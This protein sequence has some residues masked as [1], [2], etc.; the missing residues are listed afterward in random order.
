MKKNKNKKLITTARIILIITTR[1]NMNK[2]KN[3]KNE[4]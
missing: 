3:N 4:T 2:I 1:I